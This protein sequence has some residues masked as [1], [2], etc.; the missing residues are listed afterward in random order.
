M[1]HSIEIAKALTGPSL[2]LVPYR[3]EEVKSAYELVNLAV[4]REL[5]LAGMAG[6][7]PLG[8]VREALPSNTEPAVSV[9]AVQDNNYTPNLDIEQIRQEIARLA[10]AA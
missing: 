7:T 4:L 10:D 2:E 9:E 6:K 5:E 3:L 8:A 1:L